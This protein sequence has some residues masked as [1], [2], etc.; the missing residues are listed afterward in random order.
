[1]KPYRCVRSL[2]LLMAALSISCGGG[3]GG[4]GS[5]GTLAAQVVVGNLSVPTALR[6]TP[7][8]DIIFTEKATGNVRKVVNG[9]VLP[10]PIFSVS[11][12]SDGERGLLGLAIDP[13]YQA[14][15]FV[16][17]FYT[18]ASGTENEVVRFT[19]NG[20]GP[21]PTVIVPGLPASANHNGGRLE[22]GPDGKLYVT[23]GDVQNASNSQ[24]DSTPAG[25]V[26]RYNA[27]GSIP[28]DNP[29]PGNPLFSKG[30]RNCFGLAIDQVSGRVFVSENGPDCDDEV[31]RLVAGGNFGW[32]PGQPCGDNDPGFLD[33]LVRFSSV[34][35]PTGMVV[36][37]SAF[38]NSLLMASFND[39]KLRR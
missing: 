6:F 14:N 15:N 23:L 29:I 25:K 1:M 22:F 5:T 28:G 10:N 31:N 20:S 13:N 7:D 34:N 26:L 11:V 16:Y 32:R 9:T 18:K 4:G 17:V 24:S 35:A 36:G 38:G 30:H 37:T 8:G 39:R 21:N 3:G 2:A 19:D 27:N 12:E 33:P